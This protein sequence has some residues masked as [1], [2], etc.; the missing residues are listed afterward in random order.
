MMLYID[1]V[2]AHTGRIRHRIEIATRCPRTI[3]E[4]ESDLNTDLNRERYFTR[5]GSAGLRAQLA[6]RR[7]VGRSSG[8]GGFRL[9]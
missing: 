1:I 6:A 4:L 7:E 8:Q 9:A 5:V 3:R 2:D